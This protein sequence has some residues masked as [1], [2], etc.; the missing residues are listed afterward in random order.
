MKGK[1]TRSVAKDLIEKYPGKFSDNFE[2]NKKHLAELNM[3]GDMKD[4][5]NKLG[6][7]L[8]TRIKRSKR[9]ED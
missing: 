6:G 9:K 2:E 4:E 1:H 3:L 8:T 5:R 7:E